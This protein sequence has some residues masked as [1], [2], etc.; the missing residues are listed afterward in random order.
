MKTLYEKKIMPSEGV[1]ITVGLYKQTETK[2]ISADGWDCGKET[3]TE[4]VRIDKIYINR[5]EKASDQV[6]IIPAFLIKGKEFAQ[7]GSYKISERIYNEMLPFIV[8]AESH[9]EW[10]S[11]IEK[12]KKKAQEIEGYYRDK[13]KIEKAMNFGD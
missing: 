12:E 13:E 1:I 6:V 2:K 4:I 9:P 11:K 7:I 8:E 3:T 5:I 10:L